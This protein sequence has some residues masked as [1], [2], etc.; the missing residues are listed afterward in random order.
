M[1]S[2]FFNI[3]FSFFA[4][5]TVEVCPYQY[6]FVFLAV[7]AKYLDFIKVRRMSFYTTYI[8]IY[9]KCT[10]RIT[11]LQRYIISYTKNVRNVRE[12]LEVKK[13][14]KEHVSIR[15]NNAI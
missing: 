14:I 9:V 2:F 12:Y 10:Y 6:P 8:L 13:N 15:N 7:I 3:Q 11:L 4:L 1:T 5:Y